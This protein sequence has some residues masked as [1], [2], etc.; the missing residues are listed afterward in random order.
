MEVSQLGVS[1]QEQFA[2]RNSAVIHEDITC[3]YHGIDGSGKA[4]NE[5]Q[6]MKDPLGNTAKE[7]EKKKYKVCLCWAVRSDTREVFD[8]FYMLRVTLFVTIL[9]MKMN[10]SRTSP[11]WRGNMR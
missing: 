7:E 1:E 2:S 3:H 8:L 11:V 5:S 4:C 6:M 9:R 10:S